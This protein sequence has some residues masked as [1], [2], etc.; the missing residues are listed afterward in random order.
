[1]ALTIHPEV[2]ADLLKAIRPF[3]I[4]G[5]PNGQFELSFDQIRIDNGTPSESLR[6]TLMWKGQDVYHMYHNALFL[7]APVII[8]G[9]QGTSIGTLS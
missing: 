3:G 7:G 6:V 5:L 4:K 1:M 9:I 8:D 2:Y